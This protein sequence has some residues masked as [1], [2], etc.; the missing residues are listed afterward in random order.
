MSIEFSQEPFIEETK[1]SGEERKYLNESYKLGDKKKSPTAPG[2]EREK[3]T[4]KIN[5]INYGCI[6]NA[7]G[8]LGFFGEGY[9]YHPYLKPLN[10]DFHGSTFVAKTTTLLP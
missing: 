6:L 8:A 1:N 4:L 7:S 5:N 3:E 10:L 2:L 9:W